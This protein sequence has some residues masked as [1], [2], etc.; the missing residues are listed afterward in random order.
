MVVGQ[1]QAAHGSLLLL[2]V[3]GHHRAVVSLCDAGRL[4]GNVFQQPFTVGN[5]EENEGDKEH[6]FVAAL[7]I[8]QQLF[9][10][11]AVGGQIGRDNV[12]IIAGA[13][14]LLLLVD[15]ALIQICD[16]SLD[17][18]DRLGLIQGLDMH[19]DHKV[20]LHIQ[21]LGEDSILKLRRKDLQEAGLT[22][23]LA[24]PE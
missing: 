17:V 15:L 18:L 10:L 8:V 13:D 9:G 3:Q 11:G 12:H 20:C 23:F 22:P 1:R 5:M 7:Q 6:S 21:E 16:F 14:S 4:Q 19:T 2:E 24:H